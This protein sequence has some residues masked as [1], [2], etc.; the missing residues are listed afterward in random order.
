MMQI[1]PLSS[2]FFHVNHA[3]TCCSPDCLT[4]QTIYRVGQ[5]HIYMVYIRYFW[6]GNRCMFGLEIGVYIRMYTVLANPIYL[7]QIKTRVAYKSSPKTFQTSVGASLPVCRYEQL[8]VWL[9]YVRV[10]ELVANLE[11]T[12]ASSNSGVYKCLCLP[13]S[14]HSATSPACLCYQQLYIAIHTSCFVHRIGQNRIS[15][16]YD[17]MYGKFPGKNTVCTPCIL[18][19]VW[20]WPTLVVFHSP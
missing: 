5:N 14:P 16:P 6:L 15:A 19:N 13:L 17:R 3:H 20:F 7:I 8:V 1:I 2:G 4:I 11:S 12:R 9:K 10:R 18:I